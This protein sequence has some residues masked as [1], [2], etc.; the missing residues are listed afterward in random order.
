M[1]IIFPVLL[2]LFSIFFGMCAALFIGLSVSY[3]VVQSIN[4]QSFPLV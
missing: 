3:Q 4:A 1:C 2:D